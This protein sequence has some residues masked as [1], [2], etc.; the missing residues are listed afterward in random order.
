[1][2]TLLQKLR[3]AKLVPFHHQKIPVTISLHDDGTK[4]YLGS[5]VNGKVGSR[6]LVFVDGTARSGGRL[7]S[8]GIPWLSELFNLLESGVEKDKEWNL[9]EV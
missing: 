1:M 6:Q 4:W 8:W 2:E 9:R 5:A 7:C 3:K